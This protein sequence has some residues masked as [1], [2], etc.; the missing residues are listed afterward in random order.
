MPHWSSITIKKNMCHRHG[1]PWTALQTILSVPALRRLRVHE[2]L[3]APH[4]LTPS[5]FFSPA[6]I[7]PLTSFTYTLGNVL[8]SKNLPAP[9]ELEALSAVL[10]AVCGTLEYLELT[11]ASA[12]LDTLERLR[13]P[14]LRTLKLSGCRPQPQLRS[15]DSLFSNMP[16]LRFLALKIHVKEP[17]VPPA[18][19]PEEFPWPELEHL[20]LPLPLPENDPMYSRLPSSLHTLS[21][22]SYPHYAQRHDS[23]V[24]HCDITPP[25]PTFEALETILR[26]C[27]TSAQLTRLEIEYAVPS[28]PGEDLLGLVVNACPLLE[29]LKLLRYRPDLEPDDPCR[30][31]IRAWKPPHEL[32][33]DIARQLAPL[34]RLR[35]L[36]AHLD[37]GPPSDLSIVP[38]ARKNFLAVTLPAVALVVAQ[39]V[40][41][42]LESIALWV[43][44]WTFKD[45]C[46]WAV[47]RIER[48]VDR[49]AV[50]VRRVGFEFADSSELCYPGS[51][52]G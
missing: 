49:L 38:L 22:L 2:I 51:W 50:A 4:R 47:F 26:R 41:P 12:P 36:R 6:S 34:T 52:V 11:A 42:A 44:S 18:S 23:H 10:E 48:G 27:L 5:E 19:A 29:E 31:P 21:L 40:P 25:R 3:F 30:G 20:F 7:A 16:H 37:Y 1:V 32:A 35:T 45:R 24:G 8:A 39:T 33:A 17:P 28:R 14:R 13:W 15:Y 9:S 46:L 43:S